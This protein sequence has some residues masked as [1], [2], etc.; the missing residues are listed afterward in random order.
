MSADNGIY[1]HKFKKGWA[2]AH[3]QAIDNIYWHRGEK[4][5]NYN[6]LHDMFKKAKILKT[7]Q[8][9]I[10]YAFKLNDEIGFTEYG[11]CHV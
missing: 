3:L 9:A 2:V 6:I 10:L 7:R 11:V 1:I 4:N 8:E 5:Y